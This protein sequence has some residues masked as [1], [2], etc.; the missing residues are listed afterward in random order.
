MEAL[1]M[2]RVCPVVSWCAQVMSGYTSGDV[3]VAGT[4]FRHGRAT[5][6]QQL[7]EARE[8]SLRSRRRRRVA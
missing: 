1:A 5:T 2:C 8:K 6:V 7:A 3:I 4:I